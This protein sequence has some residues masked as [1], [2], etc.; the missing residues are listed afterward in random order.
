MSRHEA[1]DEGGAAAKH[2][3]GGAT[4]GRVKYDVH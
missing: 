1:P 2:V 3:A 4:P